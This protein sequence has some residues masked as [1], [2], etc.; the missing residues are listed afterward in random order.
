MTA[1]VNKLLVMYCFNY[2]HIN[3]S[4]VTLGQSSEKQF[5]YK[6]ND[7]RKQDLVLSTERKQ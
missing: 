4:K 3:W 2:P 6:L 7:C 5:L 1:E